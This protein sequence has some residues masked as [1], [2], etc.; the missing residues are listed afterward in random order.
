[1]SESSELKVKLSLDDQLSGQLDTPIEKVEDLGEAAGNAAPQLQDTAGA[2]G[3]VKEEAGQIQQPVQDAGQA[4]EETG[5][6]MEKAG[7]RGALSFGKIRSA[8]AAAGVLVALREIGRLVQFVGDSF[9]RMAEQGNPAAVAWKES[10]DKAKEAINKLTDSI[11]SKLLPATT[12]ANNDFAEMADTLRTQT[13][14]AISDGFDE[15]TNKVQNFMDNLIRQMPGKELEQ[16]FQNFLDQ[17]ESDF[18]KVGDFFAPMKEAS[19]KQ[20]DW[21]KEQWGT[22]ADWFRKTVGDQIAADFARA[23][24][25]SSEVDLGVFTNAGTAIGNMVAQAPGMGDLADR[26][27]I[28]ALALGRV[29]TA[30]ESSGQ[31]ATL[32]AEGHLQLRDALQKERQAAEDA[33]I[34]Q[35][36]GSLAIAEYGR[37]MDQAFAQAN[38]EGVGI[39]A[40]QM[41]NLVRGLFNAASEAEDLGKK[42]PLDQVS[43]LKGRSEQLKSALDSMAL[44]DE[45]RQALLLYLDMINEKLAAAESRA[46]NAA[47][48]VGGIAPAAG[49]GGG[50]APGGGGGGAGAPGGSGG[51]WNAIGGGSQGGAGRGGRGVGQGGSGDIVIHVHVHMNDREIAEGVARYSRR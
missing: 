27:D 4:A 8:L 50:M 33:R 15:A 12:E 6:K 30:A 18:D 5:T 11:T 20:N 39:T 17:L 32:S 49:G 29:G 42:V 47:A 13:I 41:D 46:R 9:N 31:A 1:M 10:A 48:A 25:S 22:F 21:L 28:A 19:Q 38:A 34:A 14:P 2:L 24:P 23:F 3:N 37:Q 51:T 45:E 16:E 44:T 36:E 26:A 7:E 43:D 35:L 40:D